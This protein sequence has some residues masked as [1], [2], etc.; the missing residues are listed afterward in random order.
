MDNSE[1]QK[2]YANV[3]S[4]IEKSNFDKL[5]GTPAAAKDMW[6][7]RYIRPATAG[8]VVPGTPN[9]APS[10]AEPNEFQNL[11][12]AQNKWNEASLDRN[13]TSVRENMESDGSKARLWLAKRT[14]ALKREI[15]DLESL[16]PGS[17][18][19]MMALQVIDENG[20]T[21]KSEDARA[22]RSK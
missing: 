3:Y 15:S 19:D 8:Q 14:E 16:L 20:V 12:T 13:N 6:L 7:A 4:S 22:D 2:A 1:L 18:R 9:G 5:G 21:I 17:G 11:I 10:N